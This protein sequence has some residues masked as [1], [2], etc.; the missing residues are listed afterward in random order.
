MGKI[1]EIS[2]E[3]ARKISEEQLETVSS[4]EDWEDVE[5]F[6]EKFEA[7]K[8]LIPFTIRKTFSGTAA[9]F[10]SSTAIFVVLP[11]LFFAEEE[12]HFEEQLQEHKERLKRQRSLLHPDLYDLP[13]VDIPAPH[14]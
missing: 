10:L 14:F 3:E 11:V 6:E 2:E 7:L 9:W 5:T 8:E 1:E 13:K 4:D 12:N